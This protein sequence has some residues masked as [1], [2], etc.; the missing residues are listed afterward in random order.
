M[1]GVISTHPRVAVLWPL[2]PVPA[3]SMP[4]FERPPADLLLDV[5][6]W[7]DAAARCGAPSPDTY[8]AYL[9]AAWTEEALEQ[10]ER[11]PELEQL[12]RKPDELW[13]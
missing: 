8:P 5:E 13:N 9:V 7:R 2:G 1:A 3:R 6:H 4:R 10:L 11:L 12:R